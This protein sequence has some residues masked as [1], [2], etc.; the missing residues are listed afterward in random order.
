[1]RAPNA[2][3]ASHPAWEGKALADLGDGE[4]QAV[5]SFV[6]RFRPGDEPMQ[7]ILAAMLSSGDAAA[8]LDAGQGEC[9]GM[10]IR[11]LSTG[12]WPEQIT[13]SASAARQLSGAGHT[14]R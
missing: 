13:G 9:P 1:V 3:R 4:V 11:Y 5:L 10:K 8:A 2:D 14:L 6:Q 12:R 7:R